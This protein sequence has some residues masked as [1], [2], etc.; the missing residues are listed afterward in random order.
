[1]T[2]MQ[3]VR[4]REGEMSAERMRDEQ[5]YS[6]KVE[7]KRDGQSGGREVESAKCVGIVVSERKVHL[8]SSLWISKGDSEEVTAWRVLS[9]L[10]IAQR[11]REAPSS[12]V[13]TAPIRSQ[14]RW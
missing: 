8:S 13:S 11:A 7:R 9:G 6:V 1:M 3:S 2:E 5:I 12:N 14:E 4:E 10:W